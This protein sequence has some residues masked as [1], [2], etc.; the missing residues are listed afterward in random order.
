MYEKYL[1]RQTD[2]NK[3]S[4]L[5]IIHHVILLYNFVVAFIVGQRRK[6]LTL[7]SPE[8][9][10]IKRGFAIRALASP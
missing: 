6:G 4:H 7:N 5:G 3:A 2:R 8:R 9:G 10:V 1:S